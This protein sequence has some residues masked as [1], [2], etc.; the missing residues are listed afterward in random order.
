MFGSK[1]R[2]DL[3]EV[4]LQSGTLFSSSWTFIEHPVDTSSD[5]ASSSKMVL[6]DWPDSLLFSLLSE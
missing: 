1:S 2:V 5:M 3:W 6:L 4:A